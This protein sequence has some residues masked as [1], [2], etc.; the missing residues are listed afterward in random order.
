MLM[1]LWIWAMLVP[2]RPSKCSCHALR[3]Y[4]QEFLKF[5][6]EDKSHLHQIGPMYGDIATS[7]LL[8]EVGRLFGKPHSSFITSLCFSKESRVLL[9]TL[10]VLIRCRW[11]RDSDESWMLFTNFLIPPRFV[12]VFLGTD[13]RKSAFWWIGWRV[14]IFDCETTSIPSSNLVYDHQTNLSYFCWDAWA[15]VATSGKECMMDLEDRQYRGPRSESGCPRTSPV[16]RRDNERFGHLICGIC[17]C[18]MTVIV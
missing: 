4:W 2:P 11:H 9:A 13:G 8:Y 12:V 5:C 3:R 14:C 6:S 18:E 17:V 10:T 7:P 16:R 1:I 15:A